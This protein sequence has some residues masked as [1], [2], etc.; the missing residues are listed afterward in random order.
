LRQ[1]PFASPEEALTHF[2]VKG[3]RWGVR[4]EEDSTNESIS[5]SKEVA[6]KN[7][8]KKAYM[9][10]AK[11]AKVSSKQVIKNVK[12][13]QINFVKKF[14]PPPGNKRTVHLTPTQKKLLIGGAVGVGVV[15]GVF[16][17]R[18]YGLGPKK[19]PGIKP[20][21]KLSIE[22][23]DKLRQQSQ[24]ASLDGKA[25][26]ITDAS[27]KRGGFEL[28]AG[29]TFHRLSFGNETEFTP[30]TYAVHSLEDFHRYVAGG[31]AGVHDLDMAKMN[32]VTWKTNKPIKVP[33]LTEVLDTVRDVLSDDRKISR[34]TISDTEVLETYSKW[35]GGGWGEGTGYGGGR[36]LIEALKSKGYGAII[37]EGDSGIRAESPLVFFDTASAGPKASKVLG[38]D[39][40]NFARQNLTEINNR[41]P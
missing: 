14:E 21:E 34:S 40:V 39:F 28:P 17:A 10:A 9:A 16:L 15:G 5:S 19:L 26:Y 2:G 18:K 20:G 37:D 24:Y 4:K 35:I 29:H 31:F 1:Q 11:S 8:N 6:S 30:T 25:R 38:R 33:E 7:A 13:D 27:F 32:H 36:K 23:F 22:A 12:Q 3:M 41:K